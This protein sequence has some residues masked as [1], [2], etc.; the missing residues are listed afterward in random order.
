VVR[1]L[2]D[3]LQGGLRPQ[4]KI[5]WS[6]DRQ[7]AFAAGKAAVSAATQLAHPWPVVELVLFTDASGSHA[8][9][10]LQQ[11][12]GRQPWRPLGFFSQK[13]HPAESYISAFDKGGSC[14]L[15]VHLYQ[16]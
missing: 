5:Q 16:K 4:H 7:A 1:P 8:G 11:R 10:V 3:A 2:T 9:A 13:L 6:E 12:V 14:P 15:S